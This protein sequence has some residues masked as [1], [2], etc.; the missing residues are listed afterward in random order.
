MTKPT[1]LLRFE[2][3]TMSKKSEFRE[4]AAGLIRGPIEEAGAELVDI[5]QSRD[6]DQEVLSILIDKRGGIRI[7]ECE[8]V[9]KTI[10]PILEEAGM[11]KDVDLFVVS[12]PGLDR[13]LKTEADFK[14]HMDEMIDIGLYQA[15]DG[16]KTF[17]GILNDYQDGAVTIETDDGAMTFEKDRIAVVKQHLEF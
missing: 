3:S 13:P 7:D 4:R 11:M 14:R 2:V 10:D 15:L 9:S 1:L 6:N 17:T 16:K 12:S 5:V 8:I